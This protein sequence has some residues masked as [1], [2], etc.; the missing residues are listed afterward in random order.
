MAR[1]KDVLK[2]MVVLMDQGK[3]TEEAVHTLLDGMCVNGTH[4]Y[5]GGSLKSLATGAVTTLSP[6]KMVSIVATA[7]AKP[8]PSA[9]KVPTPAPKVAASKSS[10]DD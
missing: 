9:P 10:L 4:C 3:L 6:D 7:P 1:A 8:K 2:R 5:Q